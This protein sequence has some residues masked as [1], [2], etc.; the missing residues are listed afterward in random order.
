M[1]TENL[2]RQEAIEK[3]QEIIDKIDV[4]MLVT[5]P[6]SQDY[7]HSVPMSRQ[8][9][10]EEGYVWFLFS[11]ESEIYQYIQQNNRVSLL[12]ADVQGYTFLSLNGEAEV[13]TDAGRIDKYWNKMVEGWFQKGREDPNIRVLCVKPVEAH[14]WD[15]KSNKL[16][17]FFKVAANALT[18]SKAD[19]GREGDLNIQN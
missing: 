17:T 11:A 2:T 13:L 18:G 4:G 15:T 14:Y 16:V 19:V 3:L 10:D 1:S 8:E 6:M 9:V 5:Y 12:Y 7:V